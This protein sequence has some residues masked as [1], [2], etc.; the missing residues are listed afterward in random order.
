[1]DQDILQMSLQSAV[2]RAS[3]ELF[4]E[5]R[6]LP[7]GPAQQDIIVHPTQ[8]VHQLYVLQEP[9]PLPVQQPVASARQAL[10]PVLVH[11]LVVCA[12]QGH[13]LGLGPQH[14]YQFHLEHILEV[15]QAV[16]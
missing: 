2:T 13:I 1:V 10:F 7:V 14:V 15:E 3:Q 12:Q 11:N 8:L 6:R 16:T 9:L 5:L 4:Q